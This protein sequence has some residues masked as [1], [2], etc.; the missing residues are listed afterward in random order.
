M[1]LARRC[2]TYALCARTSSSLSS[3]TTTTTTVRA[4]RTL[5]SSTDPV[6]LG[7]LRCAT[8]ISTTTTEM[9]C[10][11]FNNNSNVNA[12]HRNSS[13]SFSSSSSSLTRLF[14]T[15]AS[16]ASVVVVVDDDDDDDDEK[17]SEL[18]EQFDK[19]AIAKRA[20]Q[21]KVKIPPHKISTLERALAGGRRTFQLNTL[22]ND[23]GLERKDV[24]SWMKENQH[25]QKELAEKYPQELSRGKDMMFNDDNDDDGDDDFKAAE[26]L[27]NRAKEAVRRDKL[28]DVKAPLNKGP[29]GM[30]VYKGFK[31]TRLGASNVATMEKIWETG[32]HYP[33]DLVVESIRDATKLPASKIVNWFKERRE[34]ARSERHRSARSREFERGGGGAGGRGEF[35]NNNSNRGARDFSRKEGKGRKESGG[36]YGTQKSNNNRGIK[37]RDVVEEWGD[38]YE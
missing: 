29:G 37:E 4:M 16:S 34:G 8:T 11:L 27:S 1:A 31:K 18:L 30:P 28:H 19:D 36:G 35:S 38:D 32:N 33:D 15:R 14:S 20:E 2:C 13:S 24:T 7:K 25:R 21:I 26:L 9:R 17:W 5:V 12:R 6:R 22:A 3:R 23:L 10:C